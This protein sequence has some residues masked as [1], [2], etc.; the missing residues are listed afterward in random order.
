MPAQS[1]VQ[2][3]A[4]WQPDES[5]TTCPLCSTAFSW[6]YRKHHCRRCGRVV[7]GYCASNF[8]TLKAA[9]IVRP[10][11]ETTPAPE[12]AQPR[13]TLLADGPTSPTGSAQGQTLAESF[14]S[15]DAVEEVR[16]C[17][18]CFSH[19]EQERCRRMLGLDIGSLDPRAAAQLIRDVSTPSG[20]AMLAT[21]PPSYT[22]LQLGTPSRVHADVVHG[23]RRRSSHEAQ[24]TVGEATHGRHH[25]G[26]RRRSGASAAVLENIPAAIS[27]D[28]A[29]S[30]TQIVPLRFVAFKLTLS[31]KVI[32]DECPIC[33]EEYEEGQH[34][35]RLECWC[36]FHERCIMAW[37]D[38][39][40]GTHGCPLHFH[41]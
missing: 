31:D 28:Q 30:T 39:R 18:A 5:A 14:I 1:A 35:A 27:A 4:I 8:C 2:L 20:A 10:P 19:L 37:R 26:R 16:C 34:A 13:L 38:T 23:R 25:G 12:L 11:G 15:T 41:D 3:P 24:A 22:H 17:D 9:A 33:F 29:Q 40:D 36:V 32:G 6:W 21:P 7:C